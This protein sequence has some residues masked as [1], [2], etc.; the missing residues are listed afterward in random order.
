MSNKRELK[1]ELQMALPE[2]IHYLEAIVDGLR[3]GRVYL[4]HGGEVVGL[5][6]SGTVTLEVEAKQKK[7]KEKLTFE[8]SWKRD[9]TA[10][11]SEEERLRISSQRG[12]AA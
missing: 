3:Q 1:A 2:L 7:D 4:E 5:N 12:G 10:D 6:P 11:L 8:V 9:E